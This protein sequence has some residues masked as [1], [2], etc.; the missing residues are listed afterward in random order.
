MILIF[1]IRLKPGEEPLGE[2]WYS[3]YIDGV[4][5]EGECNGR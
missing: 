2:L 3:G 4:P 5:H 1:V